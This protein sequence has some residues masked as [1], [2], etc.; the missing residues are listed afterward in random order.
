MAT[1]EDVP[2]YDQLLNPTLHAL[3]RLGG[4]ASIHELV[5]EIITDMNMGEVAT[6]LARGHLSSRASRAPTRPERSGS[7]SI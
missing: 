3:H 1:R 4:S 5:D 6:F 2:T 7:H